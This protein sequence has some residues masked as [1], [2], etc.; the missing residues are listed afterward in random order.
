MNIKKTDA[1]P[2]AQFDVAKMSESYRDYAEKA[3]AQ[4]TEA[5]D[6]FK[7]VAEEATVSAQ[8]S[9]DAMREGVA[10]LSAKAIDNAR[11]NTEA[12]V[13]FIEKLAAAKTLADVFELQGEYFRASFETLSTQAKEAQDLVT[14]TGE[15]ASAPAKTVV[16]K[17]VKAAA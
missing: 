7:A 10:A 3:V 8:K 17:A 13:A 11:V 2:F 15:Q 9:F 14:K 4:S 12:G 16:Q 1:F 6:K 5:Y